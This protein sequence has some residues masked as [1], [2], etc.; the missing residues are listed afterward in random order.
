MRQVEVK[1]INKPRIIERIVKEGTSVVV[2]WRRFINVEDGL[3]DNLHVVVKNNSGIV[4][5]RGGG[6]RR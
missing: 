3:D 5:G 4:G 1:R 6:A 2:R